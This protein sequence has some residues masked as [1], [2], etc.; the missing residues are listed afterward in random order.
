MLFAFHPLQIASMLGLVHCSSFRYGCLL[1]SVATLN[2]EIK[3]PQ[4]L[5]SAPE[6]VSRY[7][8]LDIEIILLSSVMF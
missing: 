8:E 5:G 4:I 2:K 6:N 1:K 7:T 3:L